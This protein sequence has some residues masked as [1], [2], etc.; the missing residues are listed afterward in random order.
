MDFFKQMNMTLDEEETKRLLKHIQSNP[1]F[2]HHLK[3]ALL[4]DD[5][6]KVDMLLK[7]EGIK[8]I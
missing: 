8:L 2:A 5:H 3:N 4:I 7:K 1:Q 6:M